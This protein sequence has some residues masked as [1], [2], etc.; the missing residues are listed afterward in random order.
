MLFTHLRARKFKR[1]VLVGD[2]A[3][4]WGSVPSPEFDE[5]I[6]TFP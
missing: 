3:V 4:L 6:S 5:S 2:G 1:V